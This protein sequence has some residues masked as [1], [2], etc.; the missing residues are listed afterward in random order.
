MFI[1]IDNCKTVISHNT[2]IKKESKILFYNS[3]SEDRKYL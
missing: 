1:E 3:V 2:Y